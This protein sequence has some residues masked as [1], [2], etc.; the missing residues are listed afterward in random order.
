MEQ[1]LEVC[2][3]PVNPSRPVVC[4]DET[5]RQLIGETRLPLEMQPGQP[6]RYDYEYERKRPVKI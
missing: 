1:V 2:K 5:P 4:M 6:V 3:R